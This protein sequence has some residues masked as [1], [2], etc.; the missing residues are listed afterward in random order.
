LEEV[1]EQFNQDD[2]QFPQS[3]TA[4]IAVYDFRVIYKFKY[5]YSQFRKIC[6]VF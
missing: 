3:P 1:V 6:E 4:L 2:G 5:N